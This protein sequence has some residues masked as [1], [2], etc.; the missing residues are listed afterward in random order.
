MTSLEVME[1]MGSTIQM[2]GISF[3]EG[4]LEVRVNVSSPSSMIRPISSEQ[5]VEEIMD[6]LRN[7]VTEVPPKA[8]DRHTY[9]LNRMKTGDVMALAQVVKNT[10]FYTGKKRISPREVTLMKQAR[11]I[12]AEELACVT[13]N[14]ADEMEMIIDRTCRRKTAVAIPA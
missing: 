10:M 11:R 14:D 7:Q 4:R 1:I 6:F 3:Q 13:G 12:L 2:A 9:H 5:K 8:N